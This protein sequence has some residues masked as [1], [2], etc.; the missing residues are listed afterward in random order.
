MVL[1]VK[2][3]IQYTYTLNGIP[4]ESVKTQKDLG[5][6]IANDLLPASHISQITKKASQRLGLIRRCFTSLT[7]NKMQ[8][9]YTTLVRPVLEYA[10]PTWNPWFQ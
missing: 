3:A 9:L 5:V 2:E 10:S 1:R 4:L 8:T 7:A 6:L